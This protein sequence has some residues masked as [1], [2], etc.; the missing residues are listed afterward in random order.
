ME[1]YADPDE[2]EKTR[3]MQ[4]QRSFIQHGMVIASQPL[5]DRALELQKSFRQ[6]FDSVC[7]P[8][9]LRRLW[10]YHATAGGRGHRRRH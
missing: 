10:T 6:R 9:L 8:C 3:T 2:D 7:S 5:E 1:A 4:S